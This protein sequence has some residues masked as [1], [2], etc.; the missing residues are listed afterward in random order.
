MRDATRRVAS[1]GVNAP[2]RSHAF[3]RRAIRGVDVYRRCARARADDDDD[4]EERCYAARAHAARRRTP[5]LHRMRP[6]YDHVAID[7]DRAWIYD[8]RDT[9]WI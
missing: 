9:A 5:S 4:D 1:P 6:Q 8:A 3:R 7:A 2:G